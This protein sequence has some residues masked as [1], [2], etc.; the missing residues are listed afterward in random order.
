MRKCVLFIMVLA[1]S[2]TSMSL[3]RVILQQDFDNTAVFVAEGDMSHPGIGDGSITGGIWDRSGGGFD[4]RPTTVQ[5]LSGTQ[6][7]RVTRGNGGTLVGA[8]TNDFV[9]VSLDTGLVAEFWLYRTEG[10]SL[11]FNTNNSAAGVPLAAGLLIQTSGILQVRNYGDNGWSGMNQQAV[12]IPSGQWVGVKMEIDFT[13]VSSNNRIY[14]NN[15]TGYVLAS[16]NSVD[17]SKISHIDEVAF[18]P[19]PPDGASF[20][21]DDVSLTAIPEPT[22][23]GFLVFGVLPLI[24]RRK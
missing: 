20:Y 15:G 9:D 24:R 3:G 17:L 16:I 22:T 19:Q 11:V 18:L 5:A 8:R 2:C 14:Y 12:V 7:L 23:L 4:P 21:I 10:T 6:S 13:I 1:L